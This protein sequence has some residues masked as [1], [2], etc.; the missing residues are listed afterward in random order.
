MVALP[1]APVATCSAN[2]IYSTDFSF[3]AYVSG[4]LSGQTAWSGVGG[5]WALSGSVNSPFTA[6]SVVGA[7]VV[8]GVDPVGGTGQ[9]V[10]LVSEK[11]NG[12]R[13]KGYLD[14]A[15]SGKWAAASA[16]GRS[17]LETR[18]KMFV[19]GGQAVAS[20]W[21]IMIANTSF[22]TSGG[23]LV[24]AQT[25]AVSV[26]NGGYATSNRIATGASVSLNQWNEF[27]Y[28]WDV[29]TGQAT[30]RVNGQLLFSHTT[31]ASGALFA[32]NLFATTD[33]APGTNNSFGY[34]DD[35]RI[36]AEL[37]VAPC[38]ADIDS[39][40][41]VGGTDLTSLLAAWGSQS[42]PADLDGDGQV[43]G[44]DLTVLLA[45]WGSCNT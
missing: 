25:G 35:F 38:P 40:G 24:S 17:V 10:R 1:L 34:F 9:M 19:P 27:A 45:A 43:S 13:T 41:S 2:E 11:F 31:S 28:R 39:D 22:S 5:S 18:V 42:G 16:G 6:G 15:N 29:A 4:N 44:A 33:A 36:S 32:A 3:P 12:G 20:G 21:G 37:P 23:F 14:L 26:L 8:P 30:L 7:G